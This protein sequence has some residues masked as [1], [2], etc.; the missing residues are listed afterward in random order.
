[1]KNTAEQINREFVDTLGQV[2][3]SQYEEV[4]SML[5]Y[6]GLNINF[7]DSITGTFALGIASG[8][9]HTRLVQTLLS[10]GANM[11]RQDKEGLTSLIKV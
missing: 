11:N 9:G 1:M 6:R 7:E 4:I 3:W 8:L 5:I 10:K 2:D